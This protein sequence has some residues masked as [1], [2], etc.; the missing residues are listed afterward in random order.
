LLNQFK[1]IAIVTIQDGNTCFLWHDLWV[2]NIC[3]QLYPE[4]LSF[5]KNEMISVSATASTPM[6]RSLFHLPLSTE[7]YSQFLELANSVQDL[8]LTA[9]HDT[10][11]YIWGSSL[12][13]S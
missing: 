6:F 1:G 11:S 9:T 4:L 13:S 12:F 8:Q 5:A 3:S 10:W 2:S 7:S